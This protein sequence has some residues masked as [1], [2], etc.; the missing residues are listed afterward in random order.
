MS[1]SQQSH[2]ETDGGLKIAAA[3]RWTSDV[4]DISISEEEDGVVAMAV[5]Y[6]RRPYIGIMVTCNSSSIYLFS[7]H[8]FKFGKHTGPGLKFRQLN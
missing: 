8:P 3:Q 6:D 2:P 4:T 1:H 5:F 7:S